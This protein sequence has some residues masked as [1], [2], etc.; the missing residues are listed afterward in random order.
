AGLADEQC[1]GFQDACKQHAYDAGTQV[2]PHGSYL[3]NLAHT[4]RA[5]SDQAFASHL[6]DLQ[7]CER[8]GIRL[9]NIHPG[10]NQCGDRQAAIAHLAQ[11]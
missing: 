2:V 10:N 6:D 9:Y 7:R 1:R 5:R 11:N 8:L 4:D 3:V